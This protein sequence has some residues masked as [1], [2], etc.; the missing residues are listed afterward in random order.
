M[1]NTKQP[2]EILKT[3]YGYANFRLNQ[4]EIIKS[5]V[6]GEN[7][8]ALMPTGGGKS[9]CYQIP[10]M[11]RHGIGIVISPLIALM[12]D[13]VLALNDLGVSVAT[14]NS[15]TPQQA[16][17]ETMQRMR[18]N[19]IDLVY[20]SPE[21][22]LTDNLIALLNACDIALF[23]IDEAHCVSQWGHDFR[24]EYMALNVLADTF[25]NTPRIALTA[26][27]DKSTRKDIIEKLSLQ[28][29]S[30][31]ISSFDRPN[32]DMATFFW[33]YFLS[34]FFHLLKFHW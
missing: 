18:N 15:N 26:T 32:I 23:A 9:I 1:H 17:N 27:A 16:V 4:S 31:F 21:R 11:L 14:I 6:A 20:V 29:G 33:T 5:L 24:K 28:N 22:L 10:A 25:P 2:I 3:I 8:F 7:V 12:Q 30:H 13:Q 19:A 34:R